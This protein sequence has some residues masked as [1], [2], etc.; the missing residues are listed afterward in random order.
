MNLHKKNITVTFYHHHQL[1]LVFSQLWHSQTQTALYKKK[2][3]RKLTLLLL[4][5][6]KQKQVQGANTQYRYNK[7][8]IMTTSYMININIL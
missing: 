2:V 6:I 4:L 1:P 7:I 3:K 5:K 8:S